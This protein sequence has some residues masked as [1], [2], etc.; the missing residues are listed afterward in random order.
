MTQ[1][2]FNR[3]YYRRYPRGLCRQEENGPEGWVERAEFEVRNSPV[4]APVLDAL[5]RLGHDPQR[6]V[7]LDVG[8]G[9]D[10]AVSIEFSP[11][12]G[13]QAV[14]EWDHKHNCIQFWSDH[15]PLDEPY[16]SIVERRRAELTGDNSVGM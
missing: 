5:R 16:R 6:I 14:L 8:P 12:P 4:F 2:E 10:G 3:E 7:F 13:E 11:R 1:D 15:R 9:E